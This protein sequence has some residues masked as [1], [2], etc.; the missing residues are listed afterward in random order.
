MKM[1]W[2]CLLM[3][4]M[5]LANCAF[6]EKRVVN[7]VAD[8]EAEW[9][10][11]EGAEILEVYF[12]PLIG[13]D[14]CILRMGNQ[15]LM[16]DAGTS[17]QRQRVAAAIQE[18]GID[19]VDLGFNT[20]P[21]DDHIEGFWHL[22]DVVPLAWL[23]TAFPQNANFRMIKTVRLMK[24]KGIPV[25]RASDGTR[26][27]LGEA[28]VQIIQKTESWFTANNRSAMLRIQFGGC[29]LLLTADVE[30]AA[31]N[32]LV[33]TCP[34]LLEADVFKYPHHGVTKAGWNFIKHIG[35]ELAVIT[36][37]RNSTKAAAED[38]EKKMLPLLYTGEGMVRLR[39]DGNI[40]VADQWMP[41]A[42]Q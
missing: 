6:A 11:G 1:R 18:A 23:V 21:H 12:P 32:L 27:K 31:Q 16:V 22:P 35:A 38:A 37:D 3:I 14:A 41:A 26:F 34:E 13:A 29:K 17:G 40:W 8:P 33:K 9:S 7:L 10:F 24:E 30:L 25:Y 39:T 4:C 5:L 42:L 2:L 15:V 20:H 19:H 28:E 36:N